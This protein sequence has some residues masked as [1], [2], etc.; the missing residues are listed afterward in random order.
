MGSNP[1]MSMGVCALLCVG[2]V[3][4]TVYSIKEL[5]QLPIPEKWAVEPPIQF[6]SI[7][8]NVYL[9]ICKLND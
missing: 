2:R 8:L 7:L 1:P 5:K 9:L 6:K 4:L 3:L